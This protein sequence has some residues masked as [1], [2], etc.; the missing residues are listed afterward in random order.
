MFKKLVFALLLVVLLSQFTIPVVLAAG[1][2]TG[3][4]APGFTLEMAM[5]HDNHHHKHVGNDADNNG[6]GYI[7]MKP[8]TPSGKIHVHVDNNL[9]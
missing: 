4:C 1:Q 8:V 9:P 7:C 3:S 2:P 5:D 6:D